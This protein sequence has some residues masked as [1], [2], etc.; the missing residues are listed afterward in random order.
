MN[1]DNLTEARSS[2]HCYNKNNSYYIL[3]IFIDLDLHNAMSLHHVDICV[4]NACTIIF[5]RRISIRHNFRKKEL[6]I[7]YQ[8][9]FSLHPI[10]ET[11]F[12]KQNRT[13]CKK[14][15]FLFIWSACYS[16]QTI[17]KLEFSWCFLKNTQILNSMQVSPVGAELFHMF[18][19]KARSD[20]NSSRVHN[21]ANVPKML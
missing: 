18:G 2:N 14:I 12:K 6:N 7:K 21:Y 3:F 8:F 20:Q 19:Q 1:A 13:R 9:Y 5:F 15:V 10:P 11:F 17:T 16:Y 4:P